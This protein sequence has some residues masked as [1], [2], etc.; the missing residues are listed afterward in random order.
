V[1]L[2]DRGWAGGWTEEYWPKEINDDQ[3]IKNI[4]NI[5]LSNLEIASAYRT[6]Q[7]A[8]FY[9]E[10]TDVKEV[11]KEFF[12]ISREIAGEQKTEKRQLLLQQ[13]AR[14]T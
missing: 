2:V 7:D 1:R 5:V 4:K 10:I 13:L 11:I 12:G 6:L 9:K 8:D 14:F 3:M